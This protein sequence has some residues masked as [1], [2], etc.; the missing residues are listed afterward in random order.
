MATSDDELDQLLDDPA[1]STL[2]N[3]SS[4]SLTDPVNR[5]NKHALLQQL[6]LEEVIIRRE[7]NLKAFRRGLQVLGLC[8]LLEHHPQS[9]Q[10]LF[11]AGA[12]VKILT[13]QRV[14]DA[15]S[16][17]CPTHDSDKA[18]AYNHFMALLTFLEGVCSMHDALNVHCM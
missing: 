15:L 11:V 8:D 18:A 1:Y 13:A 3:H 2:L 9:L 16:S 10:P 12:Q 5:S 7:V 17:T 14:R 6:I 4:W